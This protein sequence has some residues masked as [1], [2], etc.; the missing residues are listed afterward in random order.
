M[1]VTNVGRLVNQFPLFKFTDGEGGFLLTLSR[2][3]VSDV[4]NEPKAEAFYIPLIKR[5]DR[6][7]MATW[8]IRLGSRVLMIFIAPK[9]IIFYVDR[10]DQIEEE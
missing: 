5:D 7:G 8:S 9:R 3:D 10:P 1:I 2:I 6:D 4:R